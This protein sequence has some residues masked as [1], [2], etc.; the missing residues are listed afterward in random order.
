MAIRHRIDNPIQLTEYVRAL[1]KAR[2]ET[3]SDVA[4][5]LGV[6]TMRVAAIEKDL[7]RVSAHRLI[8]LLHLLGAHLELEANGPERPTSASTRDTNRPGVPP[9]HRPRTGEW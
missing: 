5:K 3:Q 2:G 4:K 6:S 8:E 7:G 1:R 9:T